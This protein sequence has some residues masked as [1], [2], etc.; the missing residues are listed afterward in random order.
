LAAVKMQQSA[1]IKCEG[2]SAGCAQARL[3]SSLLAPPQ[4]NHQL[5]QQFTNLRNFVAKSPTSSSRRGIAASECSKFV[6]VKPNP[7]ATPGD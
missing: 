5:P 6:L 2:C 4:Q 7:L 3:G 1:S